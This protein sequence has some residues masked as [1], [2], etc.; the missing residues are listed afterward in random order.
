MK[1][2]KGQQSLKSKLFDINNIQ[3]KII[4]KFECNTKKI[5]FIWLENLIFITLNVLK[6]HFV[7][8]VKFAKSC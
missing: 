5:C 3:Y 2:A 4:N 1:A 6:L 7:E 8:Y